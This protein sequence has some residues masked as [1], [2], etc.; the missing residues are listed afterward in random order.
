MGMDELIAHAE[1]L[2]LLVKWRD[3]GRRSGELH[4]S[5]LVFLNHRK[6]LLT[7][8]VTL[9]H[10]CGHAWHGH[11]W[12][13]RHDAERDERQA[14]AYAA[15]LLIDAR[16]YAYAETVVGEHPGAIARELGVTREL[17]E[18]WRD[19]LRRHL[20]RPLRHLRAV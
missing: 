11:D 12:A 5:G 14:N 19:D 2:G 7:Q 16:D 1:A 17:V 20:D 8:R 13:G 15:R 9:A 6:S 4:S 10:E 3:L 18:L